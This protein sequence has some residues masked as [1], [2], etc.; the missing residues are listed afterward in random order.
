M[1]NRASQYARLLVE[2]GLNLQKDQLLMINAPVDAA[3]FVRLCVS[4]AYDVGAKEV[5]VNWSDGYVTRERYLHAADE[6]FDEYPAWDKLFQDTM[7]DADAAF[8][9]IAA[10]DPEML[11]GVAADR[12][13]R[14]NIA[15]AKGLEYSRNR[16]RDNINSWC[17]AAVPEKNWAKKV[18]PELDEQ[19]AMDALWEEI[20]KTMRIDG[21][22]DPVA[23]WKKHIDTIKAR[24][25]KLNEYGFKALHYKNSLGTDLMVG[26][27]ERHVWHGGQNETPAGVGFVANM[28]TEEI[29]SAPKRDAVDGVV[30]ASV[31]LVLSGNIVR[32][33]RMEL[34]DGKIVSATADEGEQ[35]LQDAIAVDEGAAYL[36]EVALVA[37][38][39]PISQSGVFFYNT[40][41]DENASCHFAFGSAYPCLADAAELTKEEML[42][43]GINSSMTHIDFMVGTDDLS[44]TGILPDG[45]EVPVFVDG[46]FA[47]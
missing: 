26:L 41:F 14:G 2:V 34:K 10:S 11:K 15:N 45:G 21:A 47:F 44:I 33:I 4:A 7:A 1:D 3:P 18:F 16:R 35:F 19:A 12:I 46:N 24:R 17:I 36:G 43:R 31:P 6:C 22:N 30:Y 40:L 8:L 29:F 25:A 27:P 23:A 13:R 32:G 28:P 5:H 37:K 39:S 20:M 9:S 42:A 38:D